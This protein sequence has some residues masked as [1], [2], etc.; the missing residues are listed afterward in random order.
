LTEQLGLS[1]I[2]AS[3]LW[4]VHGLQPPSIPP[5]FSDG[6]SGRDIMM[7]KDTRKSYYPHELSDEQKK[8]FDQGF[9]GRETPELEGL[10][11]NFDSNLERTDEEKEWDQIKPAGKKII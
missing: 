5:L 1:K 9:K 7:T 10:L 3:K 2:S 6:V 11:K 8:L 4:K